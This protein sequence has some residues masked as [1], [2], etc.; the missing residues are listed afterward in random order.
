[1]I[2]FAMFQINR[3]MANAILFRFALINSRKYFFVCIFLFL[4]I[5]IFFLFTFFLF[6]SPR[7][8]PTDPEGRSLGASLPEGDLALHPSPGG[9][10]AGVR[11]GAHPPGQL[12]GGSGGHHA[13][14]YGR[15]VIGFFFII[16]IDRFELSNHYISY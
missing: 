13:A 10:V 15:W 1:M 12:G 11:A 5:H 14:S 8:S 16:I 7:L 3:N 2:V 6:H 9:G 4:N